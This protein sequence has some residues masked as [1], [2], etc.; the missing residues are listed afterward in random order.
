VNEY[1]DVIGH[2]TGTIGKIKS[3]PD[4]SK[5]LEVATF[6]MFGQEIDV[7]NLRTEVYTEDSR[8]PEMRFGS[9][10]EDAQRRDFTIN[11]LFYNI[12][13][14]TIEDWTGVGFADLEK[15]II[16]TPL[17]PHTTFQDDP[18]RILRAIR[19]AGR[20][21]A[22]FAQDLVE[23]A[24]DKKIQELLRRKVSRERYGIEIYKML[25]GTGSASDCLHHICRFGLYE[26]VFP[27]PHPFHK[28]GEH[29]VDIPDLPS[30]PDQAFTDHSMKLVRMSEEYWNT[31]SNELKHHTVT[32]KA[33]FIL[34]GFF[35]PL[36]GYLYNK[37]KKKENMLVY[38]VVR[39]GLRL[40]GDV[41][42]RAGKVMAAAH[43]FAHF[44]QK[45]CPL[46]GGVDTSNPQTFTETMDID[47]TAVVNTNTDDDDKE[48]A[49]EPIFERWSTQLVAGRIMYFIG[50]D[51]RLALHLATALHPHIS[52]QVLQWLEEWLVQHQLLKC[53]EW[54]PFF[55]G[56]LLSKNFGVKGREIGELLTEQIQWRL[57]HP[58]RSP[59]ECMRFLRQHHRTTSHKRAKS[60]ER[61]SSST[62]TTTNTSTSSS[63]SSAAAASP[64]SSKR[65][66]LDAENTTNS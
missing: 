39:E 65:Q 41:G 31:H 11:S 12:N 2:K 61:H 46:I 27:W 44:L 54:K 5:H 53:W 10:L 38:Y 1:L 50:T 58:T 7:N 33:T 13:T 40:K 9:P 45:H 55:D 62:R 26:I 15:K 22:D 60:K 56:H 51:W 24:S 16:R 47:S 6:K 64:H 59:D 28:D 17:P 34:G 8:I 23:A 36:C 43:R 49:V 14:D 37:G 63:S 25:K 29:F 18:L 35:Y 32:D 52:T 57:T 3:N 30:D 20:Y 48:E 42:T 66:K 19:F 21:R 4:Q